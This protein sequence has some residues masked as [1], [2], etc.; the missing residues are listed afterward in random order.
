MDDLN[1]FVRENLANNNND[2]PGVIAEA[3]KKKLFVLNQDLTRF[4]TLYS[5]QRFLSQLEFQNIFGQRLELV[6]NVCQE[7]ALINIFN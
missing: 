4:I 1:Q 6:P 2:L 3:I 5:N 7:S